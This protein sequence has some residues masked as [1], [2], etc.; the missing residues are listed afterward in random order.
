VIQLGG[1]FTPARLP[2]AFTAY[3]GAGPEPLRSSGATRAA[4]QGA[5][6]GGTDNQ[7]KRPPDQQACIDRAAA[8]A[9]GTA[10]VPA[11]FIDT[12]YQGKPARVLVATVPSA[13]NQARYFVFPGGDCSVPPVAQGQG[14][15]TPR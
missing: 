14:S 13:P 6:G 12:L 9:G 2:Q 4:P 5:Y 10:L 7:A 15:A 8:K 1:E 11:F 3:S